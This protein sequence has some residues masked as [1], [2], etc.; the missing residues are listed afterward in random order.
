MLGWIVKGVVATVIL[1]IAAIS[2][3]PLTYLFFA[4]RSRENDRWLAAKSATADLEALEHIHNRRYRIQTNNSIREQENWKP[5]QFFSD[6]QVILACDHITAADQAKLQAL[7]DSGLDVNAAGK[8]SFTLLHWAW[9]TNNLPAFEALLAAGADPDRR[10]TQRIDLLTTEDAIH[11]YDSILFTTLRSWRG[12]KFFSAAVKHTKDVNQRD[13]WDENLLHTG[14]RIP[15]RLG[16]LD[17]QELLDKGIELDALDH[18]QSTAVLNVLSQ[19]RADLCL[20]LLKA[21]ANPGV[22]TER[23]ESI[24][25]VVTR[26]IRYLTVDAPQSKALAD[27]K[28]LLQ[29]LDEN[30]PVSE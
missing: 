17:L 25:E 11:Y 7:I 5:Q 3:F 8:H 29:W 6:P 20:Q 4:R 10:L 28:L 13:C 15:I 23:G 18:Y 22:L 19:D 1:C 27:F 9:S 16:A 21:G 26:K 30:H 14:T 12:Y 2:A 24:R